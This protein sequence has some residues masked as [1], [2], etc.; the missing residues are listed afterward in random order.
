MQCSSIS[1]NRSSSSSSSSNG[2]S[3]RSGSSS[4][5]NKG[6][7]SSYKYGSGWDHTNHFSTRASG[8]GGGSSG[9]SS[10]KRG[11]NTGFGRNSSYNYGGNGNDS[12]AAPT[13]RSTSLKG[14]KAYQVQ[15]SGYRGSKIT[16]A[17]RQRRDRGGREH[18]QRTVDRS[19][20]GTRFACILQPKA[21]PR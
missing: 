7:N 1:L 17:K 3:S 10:N 8:Y 19:N 20:P 18:K 4:N 15:K 9:N 13:A 21:L 5:H 6:G 14:Q 11:R 16:S 12:G 2:S